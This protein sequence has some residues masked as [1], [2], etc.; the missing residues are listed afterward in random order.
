ML[1]P[2]DHLL[3]RYYESSKDSA[4]KSF[5]IHECVESEE[6]E[7]LIC[8]Q[9][10]EDAN[11]DNTETEEQENIKNK[12]TTCDTDVPLRSLQRLDSKL[13]E[14]DTNTS[15]N[16][17]IIFEADIEDSLA[18]SSKD[19]LALHNNKTISTTPGDSCLSFSEDTLP[20]DSASDISFSGT[21]E[22]KSSNI[23]TLSST[24]PDKTPVY[25]ETFID[26]TRAGL[27]SLPY[28]M[29]EKYPTIQMLY[30]ESNNLPELPKEL[31]ILLTNLQWLDVRNN[32][33]TSLP[34]S[35]KSH[36]S[37]ET[38]LLE[39]N[40]IEKL[41]LE[42]CLVPNLKTLS[43]AR[44]P[45]NTPPK[46]VIAL[47]CSSI[48]SYLRDEWNKL[49][50]DEPATFVEPKIEPK[51]STILCYRSPR[52][53]KRKLSKVPRHMSKS[54][55]D[56]G[57]SLKSASAT[58]R[59]R[60]Y[61]P[62]NRCDAK[63]TTIIAME[64]RRQLISKVRD[65]FSA[66]SATIQRIKDSNVVKEWRRDRRSYVK[67]MEKVSRRNEDDIPYAIDIEDYPVI[68]KRSQNGKNVD[69]QKQ[70]KLRF[71]SPAN[72]NARIQ[73][74][75]EFLQTLKLEKSSEVLTPKSNQKYLQAEIEKL[76]RYQ[77]EI[78]NLRRINE[79]SLVPANSL[80][81]SS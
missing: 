57:G 27:T 49:H 45:I 16:F 5:A 80:H 51:L 64:Q 42:L 20:T 13:L 44:N 26:L 22:K 60:A 11:S 12:N 32:Q 63:E 77:T 66:Q 74:L 28:E 24:L 72:I 68:Q 18:L 38:I 25:N 53:K 9:S 8:E 31:F 29:I 67:S 30:L 15:F 55:N 76:S 37:L 35:I 33:L 75:S 1:N 81:P 69:K 14:D 46:N 65:L 61:R 3:E 34:A 62:S 59:A 2:A 17:D 19:G 40:K 78:Q 41:P 10:T 39:G 47:G 48:L 7:K 43:V 52:E 79:I 73:E 21:E 58:K 23:L 4:E 50:P 6:N 54:M 70:E 71:I 56:I 36:P